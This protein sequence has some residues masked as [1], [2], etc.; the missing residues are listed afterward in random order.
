MKAYAGFGMKIFSEIPLRLPPAHQENHEV[1]V[2][3]GSAADHI[4]EP[5]QTGSITYGLGEHK[6]T[7]LIRIPG[8]VRMRIEGDA[9]VW[10]EPAEGVDPL[11]LSSCITG[12][13]LL[14][15]L[16]K[17]PVLTLHGSAVVSEG[18]AYGFIGDQGSG[19]S[20][21]AAALSH[22]GFRV[23]CDDVTPV[24]PGDTQPTVIPGIPVP[25]L[26]PDALRFFGGEPEASAHLFD[27]IDKYHVTVNGS[28]DP[29]PLK[30][31]FVLEPSS[32]C[33]SA[34]IEL[35]QG[36][37]K[38]RT[39]FSHVSVLRGLEDGQ[40]VFSR[41]SSAFGRIP[42]WRISRPEDMHTLDRVVQLVISQMS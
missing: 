24:L 7:V 16:K 25:K 39:I 35:I 13:A 5:F 23:L 30:A 8:Y 4:P 9:Q 22:Q 34:E 31:L 15:V 33:S 27:G 14:V 41:A 2:C 28:R 36:I 42:L 26:L 18:S 17:Q 38:I 19:K 32:T 37:R 12:I 1:R 10:V 40:E 6:D 21:T 11:L 3:R 29:A 20:T